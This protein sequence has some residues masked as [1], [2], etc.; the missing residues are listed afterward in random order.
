MKVTQRYILRDSS[1][2]DRLKVY[3]DSLV[4]DPEKPKLVVIEDYKK[5]I[6][7]SQ[8]ALMWIWHKQWEEHFGDTAKA[9]HLRFKA[10]Y[11]LPILLREKIFPGLDLL[12]KDA[13][14]ILM[15]T[16][17]YG[18]TVAIHRMISTNALK[19]HQM[20]EILT[21]YQ[22]DTAVHGLIFTTRCLEY[23][24]VMGR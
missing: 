3:L 11:L 2:R 1:I 4:L 15:E 19:T 10:E 20:R 5:N 6:S 22:Q 21:S 7:A 9:E 13:E 8:R 18:P 17:D 12:L 23:K 16:G 14:D 24:E